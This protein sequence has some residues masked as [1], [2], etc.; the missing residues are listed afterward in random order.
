MDS[1]QLRP[2]DEP[3]TVLSLRM[4]VGNKKECLVQRATGGKPEW[5]G[6]ERVKENDILLYYKSLVP[7]IRPRTNQVL[8]DRFSAINDAERDV[9]V[10]ASLTSPSG[11]ALPLSQPAEINDRLKE[12]KDEFDPIADKEYALQ[13]AQLRKSIV[14]EKM[15]EDR[16]VQAAELQGRVKAM[17]SQAQ[18]RK[19]RVEN[20]VDLERPEL[21]EF[22]DEY[23]PTSG[24]NV[25]ELA[26][27]KGCN[28]DDGCRTTSCACIRTGDGGEPYYRD[29]KLNPGVCV[30]HECNR[31]CPCSRTDCGNSVV[32]K[33]CPYPLVLFKTFNGCGWGVRTTVEI[34]EGSYVLTYTG[35]IITA[36]EKKRRSSLY[37]F[38]PN[39]DQTKEEGCLFIDALNKGNLSRFV[40]HSCDPNIRV[41]KVFTDFADERLPKIVFFANR[42]I[43]PGE[44]LSINYGEAYQLAR[45]KC[46]RKGCSGANGYE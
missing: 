44:E 2:I 42:T 19:I 46:G 10:R 27:A 25:D 37:V 36:A 11:L 34:A 13:V 24:V 32:R 18:N 3:L 43:Q 23:H 22:T 4:V 16:F 39:E 14:I 20:R 21:F 45:C 40:N 31:R 5:V 30:V 26:K 41:V 35:E 15:V 28:C 29:G 38:A 8:L 1:R 9:L 7:N 6:C 33:G 17:N 12:L